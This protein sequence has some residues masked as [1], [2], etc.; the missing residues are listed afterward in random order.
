MIN[1]LVKSQKILAKSISRKNYV[2]VRGRT[3]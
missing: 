3:G 2:K 1:N